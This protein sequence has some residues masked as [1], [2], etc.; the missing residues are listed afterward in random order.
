MQSNSHQDRLAICYR[1][2]KHS[3]KIHRHSSIIETPA[4]QP[5]LEMTKVARPQRRFGSRYTLPPP[6]HNEALAN[7]QKYVHSER[8]P[9]R[10]QEQ[11][12]SASKWHQLA[13]LIRPSALPPDPHIN[14]YSPR[15]SI[16]RSLIK[17]GSQAPNSTKRCDHGALRRHLSSQN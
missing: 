13:P 8:S 14:P 4:P 11:P 9:N 2:P 1:A 16:P 3:Q 7:P 15:R 6:T 10:S 17:S 5:L 12:V